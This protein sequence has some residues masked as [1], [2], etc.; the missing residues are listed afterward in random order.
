MN[1]VLEPLADA[2]SQGPLPWLPA[3]AQT[4]KAESDS[5]I[6]TYVIVTA[7]AADACTTS[8]T[9]R[10]THRMAASLPSG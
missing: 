10:S 9:A 1:V 6:D 5:L 8:I 4:W 2:A 3:I 7:R